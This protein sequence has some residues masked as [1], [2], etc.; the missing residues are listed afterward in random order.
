MQE[1]FSNGNLRNQSNSLFEK[2]LSDTKGRTRRDKDEAADT[3][4]MELKRREGGEE[5]TQAGEDA[6]SC[7]SRGERATEIPK[8]EHV[9]PSANANDSSALP[10]MKVSISSQPTNVS[11]L[12]ASLGLLFFL[13]WRYVKY[14]NKRKEWERLSALQLQKIR[15]SQL[16]RPVECANEESKE[17]KVDEATLIK[18]THLQDCQNGSYCNTNSVPD[19]HVAK[20]RA[21]QQTSFEANVKLSKRNLTNQAR[22]SSRQLNHSIDHEAADRSLERRKRAIE[23]ELRASQARLEEERELER[24]RQRIRDAEEAERVALLEEQNAFYEESLLR[25]Q[26]RASRVALQHSMKLRR[27]NALDEAH[28]RLLSFGVRCGNVLDVNEVKPREK[29]DVQVR[30]NLPSGRRIVAEFATSHP[31]GCIYDLAMILLDREHM[32]YEDGNPP[33]SVQREA[34]ESNTYSS[35][36]N[37]WQ[38][39]FH[40]FKVKGNFCTQT[41]DELDSTF[42]DCNFTNSESV[43]VIIDRD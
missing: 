38:Q 27:K 29:S 20:I 30:L 4:N 33:D 40:P 13:L 19:E 24:E 37:E 2:W 3:S 5:C 23:R 26:E 42:H 43:M 34:S 32:L 41:L 18:G 17:A 21:E 39:I 28:A 15:S 16:R 8:E 1:A 6:P 7:T 10:W 9:G 31:I 14:T 25:D 36:Q 11:C 12:A 22:R 35:V